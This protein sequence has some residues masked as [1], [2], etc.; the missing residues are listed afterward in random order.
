MGSTSAK[1]NKTSVFQSRRQAAW[2]KLARLYTL[3][4][5]LGGRK[6]QETWRSGGFVSWCAW[7]LVCSVGGSLARLL[8]RSLAWSLNRSLGRSIGRLPERPSDQ[9]TDRQSGDG[10]GTVKLWSSRG[11]IKHDSG[12][13][14]IAV[15]IG[16][17]TEKRVSARG[18]G[19]G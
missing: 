13:T 4:G 3:R 7:S 8:I 12:T 5:R 1:A 16:E 15:S 17:D 18:P 19:E 6:G 10:G 2:G 11:V 9:S 14:Q